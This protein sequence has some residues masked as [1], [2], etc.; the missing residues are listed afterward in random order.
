[1]AL[2]SFLSQAKRN[3]ALCSLPERRVEAA[4][5][6]IPLGV[7]GWLVRRRNCAARAQGPNFLSPDQPSSRQP[8][9]APGTNFCG[10]SGMRSL[11]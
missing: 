10:H 4:L 6:S 3:V 9:N 5:L 11:P 8:I 2:R 1:M 7:A